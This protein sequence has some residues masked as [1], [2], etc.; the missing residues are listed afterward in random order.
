MKT[1]EVDIVDVKPGDVVWTMNGGY[2]YSNPPCCIVVKKRGEGGRLYYS[3][4]KW[5]YASSCFWD[6]GSLID[7]AVDHFRDA[8]VGRLKDYYCVLSWADK[9][10]T[11]EG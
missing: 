9:E 6:K 1:G 7:D 11:N 3:K 10:R 2:W 8:L 4:R 5:V